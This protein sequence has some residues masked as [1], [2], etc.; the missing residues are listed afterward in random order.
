MNEFEMTMKVERADWK[1]R[2]ARLVC[3]VRGHREVHV[4]ASWVQ[5]NGDENWSQHSVRDV[6]RVCTRCGA[7]DAHVTF[8]SD[9][10]LFY[11]D[12]RAAG[13]AELRHDEAG[14]DPGAAGGGPG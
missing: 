4:H 13:A 8:S 6:G 12:D 7:Q 9:Q 1:S 11:I 14:G 5:R 3:R 10:G 2:L